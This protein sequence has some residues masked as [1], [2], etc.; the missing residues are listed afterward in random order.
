MRLTLNILLDHTVSQLGVDAADVL[1][2][3]SGSNILELVAHRGFHSL[4]LDST[5]VSE[6]FAKRA[7]MEH[8]LISALDFEIAAN[9]QFGKLWKAEGFACYWCVPLIVKGEVK[10]VLEVYCRTEFTPD[11]EW[12][13]FLEALAG[14]A[15]I[16]IDTAQ[17]F[18]NLQRANLDLS[19]AY[20]ATIEGWSRAMDLRDHETEGHTLRVTELT[21]KLARAL[22]ISE[23]HLTAIRHGTLL[24]DIGKIGV[25]DA[26]LLKEGKLTE[27]EWVMMHK[28]PQ[29]AHDMLAPIAYLNDSLDIPYCHHEKWD[30]TGYPQGLRGD[31]IPL[32]ARIFAVVDVWDALTNDRTYRKKWTKQKARQYIK[33]QSGRH[34]DPHIVDVFLKNI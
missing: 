22:R 13:E 17:L 6:S 5:S 15:A 3:P 4:L 32:I 28:H 18:E 34:F 19:L 33:E 31:R 8:R 2:L 24:H 11:A 12:F 27:E 23:S 21:L 9:P 30:G 1:L 10:G 29:L 25:P 14:Q 26:I 16:T 20:D 7:I